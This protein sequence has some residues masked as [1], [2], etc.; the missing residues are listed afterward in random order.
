[1]EQRFASLEALTAQIHRDADDARAWL[2]AHRP[3]PG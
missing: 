3:P 2:A 1:M